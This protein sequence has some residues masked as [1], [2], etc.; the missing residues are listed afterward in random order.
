MPTRQLQAW[1]RVGLILPRPLDEQYTFEDLSQMRTLRDLQAATRITVKSIRASVEAMQQVSGMTNPLLETSM[2]H[3]GSRLAFRYAGALV[4]P[5]TRQLSFDFDYEPDRKLRVVR[6]RGQASA[7][8]GG[9]AALQDMFLRAVRLE[10][11]IATR[12]MAM[13][14]YQ[15]ILAIDPRHAPACIN[16]GTIFYTLRDFAMAE[17]MYRRATLSD[18][19]YALAFFDLGNVLDELQ[20]LPEAIDAYRRAVMLVPTYADAHYNLALAYERSG[21]RR[22]ALSHW[23]IYARLDPSGPWATHA[24][25]QAKKI[26]SMERLSIITRHGT[27]VEET[28]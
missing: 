5:M 23:M 20:R 10:E 12:G 25:G 22:R 24:K 18:P 1:E 11:D 27:L 3:S 4:D 16:L 28:A 21:E 26:L 14:L 2:V 8:P 19:D 6:T 17:T 9:S 13:Q 15:D 7:P